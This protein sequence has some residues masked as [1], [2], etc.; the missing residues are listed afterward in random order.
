VNL[1]LTGG[2]GF[3]GRNILCSLP[4]NWR[5][6]APYRHDN[7]FLS[8]L[9]EH[10]TADVVPIQTD[11]CDSSA[12]DRLAKHKAQ[13]DACLYLAANG[14]P[15]VSV[16]QPACDLRS[17]TLALVTVLERIRADHLLFFSSGA[18]YDG[19]LGGVAPS[20]SLAPRLPYAI[21]KLASE[22]YVAHFQRQGRLGSATVVRFF[23]AYGRYEPPR[24]IFNRLVRQFAFDR[25][26]RFTIRGDGRNLIDAMH[27]DDAVRA[28]HL[29]LRPH[30]SGVTTLDLAS[31]SPLTLTDL[32]RQA[33]QAFCLDAELSYQGE[34]PEYIEF[35]S[36]DKRMQDD[37]AFRPAISLAD[38]LRSFA[39]VLQENQ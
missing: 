14:D 29:L 18:V 36:T 10:V 7:G 13:F 1:L 31:G 11:L 9:E 33:G 26:P 20:T 3:I 2:S 30:S 23:G 28:I 4:T 8:F 32:V 19:I 16:S 39:R 35:F 25:D 24:K 12:V 27:V 34:V 37:Y 15:A 22:R 6:V 38:G 21:S 5:V 17:N